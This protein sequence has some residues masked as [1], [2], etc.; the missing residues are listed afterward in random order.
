MS[1]PDHV[2]CPLCAESKP[3][4][5][6]PNCL[7]PMVHMPWLAGI[8]GSEHGEVA[9]LLPMTLATIPPMLVALAALI[10]GA[11][12]DLC[13]PVMLTCLALQGV[14]LGAD[15]TLSLM[16]GVDRTKSVL[17]EGTGAYVTGLMK[18]ALGAGL[19]GIAL[20]PLVLPISM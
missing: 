6:C 13:V 10:A 7:R 15:G 18:L 9:V 17:V 8:S 12:A 14:V 1:M 2:A 5:R 20:M 11:S 4:G 19:V 16:S 3:S